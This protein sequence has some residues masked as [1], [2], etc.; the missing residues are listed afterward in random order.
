MKP[1]TLFLVA[2]VILLWMPRSGRAE[3]I[4]TLTE[5]SQSQTEIMYM[6]SAEL[7]GGANTDYVDTLTASFATSTDPLAAN[8]A[9]RLTSD[10]IG[11][12]WDGGVATNGLLELTALDSSGYV[13]DGS[14]SV[15]IGRLKVDLTGLADGNYTV[16]L[17]SILAT[18]DFGSGPEGYT[19]TITSAPSTF[20]II[21]VPEP[22][23]LLSILLISGAG[24]GFKRLGRLRRQVLD[25]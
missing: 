3:L 11:L 2:A 21:S 9:I 19:G 6:I 22:S 25:R 10:Q 4:L 15:D 17:S 20:S 7:S 14:P 5:L 16:Q 18:G 1:R 8:N 24:I 12:L 13:F 23:T